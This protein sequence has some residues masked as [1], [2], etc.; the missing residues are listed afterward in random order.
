MDDIDR[1]KKLSG[2]KPREKK[3]Q[4]LN[5]LKEGY[6]DDVKAFQRANNLTPDGIVGPQTRAAGWGGSSNSGSSGSTA[7]VKVVQTKG[8]DYPV[9]PKASPEAGSFRD[10]FA[11]ARAEQGAGGT[12]TWQGRQYSTNR[13][14]D[15][16]SS[17]PKVRPLVDPD[18]GSGSIPPAGAGMPK[19]PLNIAPSTGVDSR[20]G[21][22]SLGNPTGNTGQS[23]DQ[24]QSAPTA[25]GGEFKDIVG[26]LPSSKGTYSYAYT[27]ANGPT[28]TTPSTS[29]PPAGTGMPAQGYARPAPAPGDMTFKSDLLSKQSKGDFSEE[30][31]EE[32]FRTAY[33]AAMSEG[34]LVSTFGGGIK[35]MSADEI[36][37]QAGQYQGKTTDVTSVPPG[38]YTDTGNKSFQDRVNKGSNNTTIDPNDPTDNRPY[39]LGPDG[40][41]LVPYRPVPKE[42]I[43]Q[44]QPDR[45]PFASKVEK[46]AAEALYKLGKNIAPHPHE[47]EALDQINAHKRKYNY[48]SADETFESDMSSLRRLAGLPEAD[49]Q[50]TQ[51][52][53][54]APKTFKQPESVPQSTTVKIPDSQDDG[55]SPI[56][57]YP[58]GSP[59]ARAMRDLNTFDPRHPKPTH[60]I[61]PDD[62]TGATM[63]PYDTY[64]KSKG[65]NEP[66]AEPYDPP[67]EYNPYVPSVPDTGSD[68]AEDDAQ[69]RNPNA[70]WLAKQSPEWKKDA[71]AGKL[72]AT[73]D[74][75]WTNND[76]VHGNPI[77]QPSMIAK[78]GTNPRVAD[79][80][81]VRPLFDPKDAHLYTADA[82]KAA[83][84]Q[85]VDSINASR[86]PV[87]ER[88]G[89]L[90]KVLKLA[91]LKE[92][93]LTDEGNEFSGALVKAKAAHKDKFE[94]DGKTY[95]VKEGAKPDYLDMDK[96]GD[97]EEAMKK[98]LKDKQ[99]SDEALERLK[100]AAGIW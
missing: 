15:K 100:M 95:K 79:G 85:A 98:A 72:D 43:I 68:D 11:S 77:L 91:G 86:G 17:T 66:A 58:E 18:S 94:V 59:E 47:Q 84:K 49:N 37:K 41:T 28:V 50:K 40:K 20:F 33:E 39:T 83:A 42:T 57:N 34:D 46:D 22:P 31:L 73:G 90:N 97:K 7:P 3:I 64:A 16:G 93:D 65:W 71:A 74:A 44:L 61:H 10:A 9:Y 32:T 5:E 82:F 67:E 1:L 29:V 53:K 48:E 92:T 99:R 75:A 51:A 55:M 54:V 81:V 69:P 12:F 88:S 62:S 2:V 36:A 96:D 38:A 87:S 27:P 70:E 80:A 6:K 25:G 60:M 30:E 4:Q 21:K 8:G 56:Y 45:N 78:Y 24:D 14:D 52:K 13:A 63:V 26:R 23:W 76:P 35:P 19:L 89:E